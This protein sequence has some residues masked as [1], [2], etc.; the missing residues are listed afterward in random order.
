VGARGHIGAGI[1]RWRTCHLVICHLVIWCPCSVNGAVARYRSSVRV[2]DAFEW[3]LREDEVGVTA[4][5]MDGWRGR[6]VAT[7]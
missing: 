5:D 4:G 2:R 1:G 7:L 3:G 6:V